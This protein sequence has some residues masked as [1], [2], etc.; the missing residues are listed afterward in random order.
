ML[1]RFDDLSQLSYTKVKSSDFLTSETTCVDAIRVLQKAETSS[2]VMSK[3]RLYKRITL[4]Q[5]VEQLKETRYL[6]VIRSLQQHLGHNDLKSFLITIVMQMTINCPLESLDNIVKQ[7]TDMINYNDDG[8]KQLIKTTTKYNKTT[9]KTYNT[10]FPLLQLP[11]D[12]VTKTSLFLNET[13]IFNYEKCCRLFYKM[14]NNSTYLKKTNNFK[15]FE[16]TNERLNQMQ[17]SKHM[18]YI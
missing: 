10:S 15:I 18:H 16:I 1:V 7:V 2:Q 13:D 9:N 17:D 6:D 14:I 11:V 5:C 12:L 3:S 8:T 4:C